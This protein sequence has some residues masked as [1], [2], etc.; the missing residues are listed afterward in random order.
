MILVI[1]NGYSDT[2]I[3][4]YLNAEM[5]VV[6]SFDVTNFDFYMKKIDM[7][8]LIIILGGHQSVTAIDQHQNLLNVVQLIKFCVDKKPILGICLGCQLL[9]YVFDCEIRRLE[10]LDCG[11]DTTVL[12]FSNIF[13]CHRDYI[14][15][16]ESI[17]LIETFRSMPYIFKIK[18]ANIYGI[19]CHP[20]IPPEFVTNFYD[21]RET[22]E[23][24]KQNSTI[25]DQNNRRC[26]EY[27]LDKLKNT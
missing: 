12:D 24:A 9:A 18:S 13:R 26:M 21:K 15:P 16:N 3:S 22:N 6:K 10:K 7:Y 4:N 8:S 27:L 25:I 19:Q 17:E 11:Y 5:E 20:D 1:Q 2:H 14:V 23:F